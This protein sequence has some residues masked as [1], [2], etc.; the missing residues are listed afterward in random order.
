VTTSMAG[1]SFP[2][3]A[4]A[5]FVVSKRHTWDALYTSLRRLSTGRHVAGVWQTT[6]QS[7]APNT[8]HPARLDSPTPRLIM[9]PMPITFVTLRRLADHLAHHCSYHEGLETVRRLAWGDE[10]ALPP[11][12]LDE[13]FLLLRSLLHEMGHNV[14]DR[15]WLECHFP[16][17][18]ATRPLESNQSQ[19][20][21]SS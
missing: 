1:P 15:A 2:E 10:A 21:L 19:D 14:N 8:E 3:S 17:Y 6:C 13:L 9:R 20:S 12:G 16:D 5:E 4:A 11:L 7:I 18:A